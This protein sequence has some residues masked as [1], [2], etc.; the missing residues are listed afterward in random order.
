[1]RDERRRRPKTVCE[2]ALRGTWLGCTERRVR[3]N[4]RSVGGWHQ[5][6]AK[7]HERVALTL[8]RV[9]FVCPNRGAQ[10]GELSTGTASGLVLLDKKRIIYD[11]S[12]CPCALGQLGSELNGPLS[13]NR[14]SW[15]LL[16]T[17]RAVGCR[18]QRLPGPKPLWLAGKHL[19]I[20]CCNNTQG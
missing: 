1:M 10:N 13:L 9:G 16:G 19:L 15:S 18:L 17:C 8:G 14:R 12:L 7:N 3:S 6:R 2:A 5:G 4:F 11:I 20:V